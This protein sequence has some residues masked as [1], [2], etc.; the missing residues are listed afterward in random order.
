M[1][2]LQVEGPISGLP[3]GPGHEA[4][5]RAEDVNCAGHGTLQNTGIDTSA[6]I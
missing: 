3:D 4:V 1:D 5:G 6:V 2:G